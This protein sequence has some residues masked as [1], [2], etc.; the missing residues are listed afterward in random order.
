[1]T[2]YSESFND[3]LDFA[4][5]LKKNGRIIKANVRGHPY[6]I[7]SDEFLKSS[8]WVDSEEIF[9][10][11]YDLIEEYNVLNS[12]VVRNFYIEPWELYGDQN[13]KKHKDNI[14]TAV[15]DDDIKKFVELIDDYPNVINKAYNEIT[16]R[17]EAAKAYEE[18]LAETKNIV[19]TKSKSEKKSREV[20]EKIKTEREY[21]EEE[22]KVIIAELEKKEKDRKRLDEEAKIAA[23]EERKRK[24]RED[25]IKNAQIEEELKRKQ[26]ENERNIAELNKKLAEEKKACNN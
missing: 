3:Y 11:L 8:S 13:L 12:N 14:A 7:T 26:E 17:K 23:T 6:D 22:S 25:Q 9:G 5:K 16:A 21:F 4:D 15:R 18:V 19:E 2:D 20:I 24:I 10:H 1:M